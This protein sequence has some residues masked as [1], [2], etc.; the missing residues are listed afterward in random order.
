VT[1]HRDRFI[2]ALR[3]DSLTGLFDPVSKL[4]AR[5]GA[6]KRRVLERAALV[7]G[8]RV[9]DLAC[10]TGTL[11]L[12]AARSVPGLRVT[13]VDGDRAILERARAK[14]GRE[15]A[16]DQGLSTELPYEDESFDV[17]LSTLFFHHL[18][19]EAKLRSA[20]EVRRVLRPA[21]R[22]VI[23][24]VGRPQD[25]LMRVAVRL[26]VQ[27]LDGLDVTSGS[28]AGRLPATLRAGGLEDVRVTDRLRTPIGTLEIVTACR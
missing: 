5:E 22:V 20:E 11:A 4:T 27:L 12:A 2:P 1:D 7:E 10:G 14:A 18:S 8:Q 6:F 13:G 28:V 23:G 25:P 17:V 21:G 9:L 26:T 15:V 3:F 24:D 16:F 19:D